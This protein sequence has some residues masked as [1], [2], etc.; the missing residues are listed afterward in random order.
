MFYI[1]T[2]VKLLSI[3]CKSKHKLNEGRLP[4]LASLLLD[5]SWWFLMLITHLRNPLPQWIGVTCVTNKI[6]LHSSMW[7]N[8][9][10]HHDFYLVLSWTAHSRES[11]SVMRT[12]KQTMERL[13]REELLASCQQPEPTKGQ[14]H[15]CATFEADVPAPLIKWHDS[16][17]G[18][19]LHCNL[20]RPKARSTQ[21]VVSEFLTH[22]NGGVINVYCYFKLL[23]FGI[24]YAAAINE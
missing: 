14:A 19:Y 5:G 23:C 22:R 10:R 21:K 12:L 17:P 1:C 20:M 16:S 9:I 11:Q 4:V 8:H 6:L 7:L 3:L 18:T 13:A 24:T 2:S 15:E